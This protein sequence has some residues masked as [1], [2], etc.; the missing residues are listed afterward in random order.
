MTSSASA[1]VVVELTPPGRA[2]VAVVVV[3]GP[4]A[5]RSVGNCF[6]ARSGRAVGDIPLGRIALGNWGGAGGEELVLCRRDENHIE[7]HCH[8]GTAAVETIISR[9]LNE[10]CRRLTWQEWVNRC[11]PDRPQAAAQIALADA[12]TERTAAILL[13]QLN[14]ALSAAIRGIITEVAAAEWSAA[15]KTIDELLSR[16]ELG[17]HLI[18]PWRIVVFGA[19]NVGK[20]SLINA[21]A[22]YERAIVSPTPGTTRDVVTVKTAIAGWPVQL[23]DTA[24]FRETQD[25]LESAGI[26]L[27]TT[28][29]FQAD[30]AIFVHDAAR[31]RDEPQDG[32]N[33]APPK[34][35]PHVR[36][37]HVIN[38]IDLISVPER[39]QLLQQFVHPRSTI[40]QPHLVSALKGE[41]IDDLISAIAGTLVPTSFPPGSAV[42]FT[43]EQ[44]DGL[45]AAKAAVEQH[46][47]E[48]ASDLLHALLTRAD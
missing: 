14:G 45:T 18:N 38:K 27:A 1:T 9:L 47:A 33:L 17:Q 13:D 34:L 19:P 6:V 15:A 16:K 28:T 36:A 30:L 2:A 41:G 11:T 29:L 5:L 42:P 10:G 25:E 7:V 4:D 44:V 26:K 20:S 35:A 40:G 31:P 8:G 48:V 46:D 12:V 23:S 37:L 21:L 24:G 39:S 3:A 32:T 22:G 43:S